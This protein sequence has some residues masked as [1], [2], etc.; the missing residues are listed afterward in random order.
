[1]LLW[2]ICAVFQTACLM[3]FAAIHVLQKWKESSRQLH[4]NNVINQETQNSK[5]S[6]VFLIR[7]IK[8]ACTNLVSLPPKHILQILPNIPRSS[9]VRIPHHS[10][11]NK[12]ISPNERIRLQFGCLLSL[13]VVAFLYIF[14]YNGING[15]EKTITEVHL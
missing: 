2:S 1:M 15:S 11:N 14:R 4:G 8:H 5:T 7:H 9:D 12:L 6:S 13:S 3:Q 10:I